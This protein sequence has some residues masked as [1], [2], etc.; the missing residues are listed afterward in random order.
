[1]YLKGTQ[2][3]IS[4]PNGQTPILGRVVGSL[5]HGQSPLDHL[6]P[7]AVLVDVAGQ[8]L[9]YQPKDLR[10]ADSFHYGDR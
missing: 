5:F 8:T 10:I 3:R 6:E 2:V 7:S 4:R 9:R 1:M